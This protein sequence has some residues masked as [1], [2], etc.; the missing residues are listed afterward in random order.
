MNNK[1]YL[2]WLVPIDLAKE[3]KKIGFDKECVFAFDAIFNELA[4]DDENASLMNWNDKKHR[5]FVSLPTWEQAFEWF[6]E[7]GFI[8]SIDYYNST[9][10]EYFPIIKN[11]KGEVLFCCYDIKTYEQARKE[12]LNKLIDKFYDDNI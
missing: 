11:R 2:S 7:K 9:K 8:T 4:F 5:K 1:N 3:L 12:L 10:P 6:R